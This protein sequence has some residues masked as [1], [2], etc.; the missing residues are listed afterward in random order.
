MNRILAITLAAISILTYQAAHAAVYKNIQFVGYAT[1]NLGVSGTGASD[2]WDNAGPNVTV[3][4]GAGSLDGTPLG[5]AA[6]AGDRVWISATADLKARNNFVAGGTFPPASTDTNLYFSFLYKFHSAANAN[7]KLMF[8]L[9]VAT[10]GTGTPQFWDM[11]ATNANGF[12]QVGVTK[13]SDTVVYYAP[14]NIVEGAT[15]FIVVRYHMIVGAQ[16]DTCEVWVNPPPGSFGASEVNVPPSAAITG[17]LTT[18]GTEA[19]SASG[20]GRLVVCGGVDAELDEFRVTSS[21]AEATPLNGT[22]VGAGFD[23]SPSNVTQVAEIGASFTARVASTATSPT[24]QW[25]ISQNGGTTWANIA[26]AT[27]STYTTPNLSLA[28]DN[29]NQYQAIC[30]VAC[31][32]S[33]ATSSVAAVTLTA[34]AVTPSGLVVND[35]FNQGIAEPITPVTTNNASWYTSVPANFDIYHGGSPGAPLS[36]TPISGSSSLWLAYF[37]PTNTPPVH[38]GV[39]STMKVTL[40]FSPT[41]YGSHTGNGAFRIGVFDYADGGIRVSNDDA[42]VGGS[43]GNG[44]G[45]RGYVLSLDF[46]PTFTVN[47]PLSTLA[48]NN[49]TDVN[50]MGSTSDFQSLGSGPAGG[51]YTN[52]PAFAAG[53]TYNLEMDITRS[54]VN[55]VVFSNSIT[56]AGSNWVFSVTETN[57]AYHRFD[58]LAIRPN[59]LET[60]ADSININQLK[61]EVIAPTSPTSILLGT[62][63]RSGNTVTLT[64]TPTPSGS[65]TYSVQRRVNLTDAW[66]TLQSGIPAT[67]YQDTAATASTGFYRVTSP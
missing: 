58:A 15:N 56:G 28:T 43:A 11:L 67:T 66:S 12:I 50:L 18:D 65:F 63:T 26:G 60:S 24:L 64:W 48:R 39:G 38:L 4:N 55:T 32:N 31:N 5:L 8:R 6:S 19:T 7:G 2:G 29:G 3:T 41:A 20:P 47:S 52:L 34:P 42:T 27:A 30:Y 57:L 23:A 46:G 51:G 14:S 21:W 16:N 61:V 44:V 49:L 9:N 36:A 53:T 62:V 1:G 13:P 37:T 17:T 25:Q 10:S 59:S 33:Y 45:V 40:P 35:I 22:C 54:G